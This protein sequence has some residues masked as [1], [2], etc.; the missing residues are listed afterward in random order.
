MNST[1]TVMI[2]H[3]NAVRVGKHSRKTNKSVYLQTCKTSYRRAH[4]ICC[5][6]AQSDPKVCGDS[7]ISSIPHTQ[8]LISYCSKWVWMAALV[9]LY[10]AFAYLCV[11]GNLPRHRPKAPGVLNRQSSV[12]LRHSG[13]NE[14]NQSSETKN[15]QFSLFE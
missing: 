15:K 6:L 7:T 8:L 10:R 11:Y 13:Q 2:D 4:H 9:P 1:E 12:P 14:V 3:K 5:N